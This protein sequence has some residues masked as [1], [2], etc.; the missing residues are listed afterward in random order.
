MLRNGE[1]YQYW[2]LSRLDHWSDVDD[3]FDQLSWFI[4]G[5]NVKKAAKIYVRGHK[6]GNKT[7]VGG[8]H[9]VLV[10]FVRFWCNFYMG[11]A[12]APGQGNKEKGKQTA[13]LPNRHEFNEQ[14]MQILKPILRI[15]YIRH[16]WTEQYVQEHIW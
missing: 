4:L 7:F 14:K 6:K 9:I 1:L 16:I 5:S 11:I 8:I 3:R 15:Y 13:C 12:R 10:N 2:L